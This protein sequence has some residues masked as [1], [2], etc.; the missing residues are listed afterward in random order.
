[1]KA[2]RRRLMSAQQGESGMSLVE[3]LVAMMIFAFVSTGIIYSMLATLSITRDAR[4]RQVALNLAAQEID[5]ARDAA[6]LFDLYDDNR[7]VTLNGDVYT[8]NRSTQWVSDPGLDLQCGSSAGGSGGGT[9][10]YKRVNVTVTWENMRSSTT[11]VRSDTVISPTDHINDPTLGTIL[12]SVLSGDGTGRSG[13]SVSA[14]PGSPA[15]GA[16]VLGVAPANTDVQ[17]CSY[18]LSVVPGNYVVTV[19][20]SG[21][22]DENQNGTSTRTIGVA[23]GTAASAGFQYDKAATLVVKYAANY[24]PAAGETVRIPNNMQTSFV[25]SYGTHSKPTTAA[26]TQNFSLFPFQSGY[27]PLAGKYVA[28]SAT[29]AGCVSVDP[30]AWPDGVDVDGVTPITGAANTSVATSGGTSVNAPV[31]MGVVRV[32]SGGAGT[33]LKAVS[34]AP[35]GGDP[36]CSV[37]MTYT[38]GSVLASPAATIALPPGSWTLYQ[39]GSSSQ[40]QVIPSAR[41]T[42]LTRGIVTAP[43]TITLDPRV[44]AP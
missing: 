10:R 3:V 13:V 6:D 36:G 39:G 26:L 17:G 11:P 32:A 5:L 27:T 41:L 20:R 31:A 22:V 16:A 2:I 25:S 38:F 9:L 33:Y 24:T 34:A 30:A 14:A 28:E 35:A 21:Y 8:V 37:P 40:T 12:V 42:P 19:S 4:A 23:A 7:T 44:V 29:D 18:I 15:N 1:M 43:S